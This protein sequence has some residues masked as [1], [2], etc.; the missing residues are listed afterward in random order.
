MNDEQP[1]GDPLG[2]QEE[3][4]PNGSSVEERAAEGEHEQEPEP[5]EPAMEFEGAAQLSLN[6]GHIVS[7]RNARKVESSSLRLL[8]GKRPIAN[9]L[10]IDEE[11]SLIVRVRPDPPAPLAKRDA[12]TGKTTA[13]DLDQT[14]QI[15]HMRQATPE[16]LRDLFADLLAKDGEAAGRLLDELRDLIA[17]PVAA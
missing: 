7:N 9:L 6:L 4:S 2:E 1:Q 5:P 8:G 11:Y 17:E 13:F 12:S 10:D 16:A 15:L 3:Q 14:A